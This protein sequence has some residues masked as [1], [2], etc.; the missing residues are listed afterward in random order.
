MEK[1]GSRLLD[2]K[3]YIELST[4]NIKE[5]TDKC[6]DILSFNINRKKEYII[7]F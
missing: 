5:Y 1:N 4:E 6:R 7:E 2:K 3:K